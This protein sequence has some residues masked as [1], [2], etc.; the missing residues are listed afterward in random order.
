MKSW[1]LQPADIIIKDTIN[2]L[3]YVIQHDFCFEAP[4][5][6]TTN[7]EKKTNVSSD[8]EG[9]MNSEY[10]KSQ[11]TNLSIG[12]I[13]TISNKQMLTDSVINVLQKMF[14]TQFQMQMVHGTYYYANYWAIK[15][16]K[17]NLLLQVIHNCHYHWTAL[18]T[19]GCNIFDIFLTKGETVLTF[20]LTKNMFVL[21]TSSITISNTVWMLKIFQKHR[22]IEKLYHCQK[23]VSGESYNDESISRTIISKA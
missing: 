3:S 13:K 12:D 4:E 14:K 2:C 19:Y 10:S 20:W 15:Y 11:R 1:K 5:T 17:I 8:S 16:I 21:K 22:Y 6:F 23:F 9:E 18:S 7:S